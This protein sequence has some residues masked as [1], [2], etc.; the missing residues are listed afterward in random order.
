MKKRTSLI[1]AAALAAV[2]LTL[3][4]SPIVPAWNRSDS[5]PKGLYVATAYSPDQPLVRGQLACFPYEQPA[6]AKRYYLYK[7][8]ILCKHVLG[9]PGDTI[10]TAADGTNT[11][12]HDGKCASVGVALPKD[13][14]GN[15]VK[16][17]VWAGDVIPEGSYYMG[18]TRRPNSLD[19][20]YLGLIEKTK[21]VKT[22]VPLLVEQDK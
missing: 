14:F 6:W 9:M 21:I 4:V 10:T 17:P 13:S 22:L 2:V 12:C 11:I 20:R 8:E 18:S 19:S 16:H 5:I 7:G 15:D 1:A 3:A